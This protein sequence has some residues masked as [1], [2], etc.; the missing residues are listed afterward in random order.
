MK[1][2]LDGIVSLIEDGTDMMFESAGDKRI[3]VVKEFALHSP[4][5]GGEFLRL[6][7]PRNHRLRQEL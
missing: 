6:R 2:E 5:A 3:Q 1:V 7:S 4:E